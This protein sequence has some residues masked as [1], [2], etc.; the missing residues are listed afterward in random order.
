MN[1][2]LVVEKS[3]AKK[4]VK[5]LKETVEIYRERLSETGNDMKCMMKMTLKYI[6]HRI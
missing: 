3:K 2:Q 6:S 4:I 1:L 5:M